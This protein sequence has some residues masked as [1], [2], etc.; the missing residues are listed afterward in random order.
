VT[1]AIRRMEEMQLNAHPSL[2]TVV[3]DGWLLRF[4]GGYTN[5]ANSVN[6]LYPS[7]IPAIE[8]ID[9]CESAYVAQGLPAVF[10]ITPL[11]VDLDE[12][13]A[14]RGYAVVTPTQVMTTDI[15]SFRFAGDC[16]AVTEGIHADWQ[17]QYFR[18]HDMKDES[19][20]WARR[21]QGNIQA[22]TLTV[23]VADAGETVACGMCV[24]EQGYAGLYDIIVS[25]VHR[26]RG[27]GYAV[28][29]ALLAEAA[30][31]GAQRAYLQVVAANAAAKA[32]YGK[33]GFTDMYEYWYRVRKG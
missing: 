15:S 25:P 3:H 5:R 18:L 29:A 4:A 11:S 8:K 12:A 13:L 33:L 1:A 27:F 7:Q 10:K 9:F 14:A 20:P 16:T 17:A 31:R 6:M 32:L 21:I 24:L 23:A 19:I 26:R 28:C 22:Q 2:Q 30:K